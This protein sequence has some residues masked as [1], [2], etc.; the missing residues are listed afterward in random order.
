MRA[1]T[2]DL[3]AYVI[4]SRSHFSITRLL[5]HGLLVGMKA[6]LSAR[7]EAVVAAS[8]QH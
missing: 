2:I 5:S 6:T 3:Y 7:F 1:S 8:R 4:L